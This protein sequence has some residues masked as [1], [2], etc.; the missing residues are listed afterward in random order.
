MS[1]DISTRDGLFAVMRQIAA[2]REAA[3]PRVADLLAREE[4]PWDEDIPEEWKTAGFVE[5]LTKAAAGIV[6]KDPSRCVQLQLLAVVTAGG[7]SPAYPSLVRARLLSAA[8]KETSYAYRLEGALDQ[9][10]QAAITAERIALAEPA[11]H[12]DVS[13]ARFMRATA[14]A[15]KRLFDAASALV[16]ECQRDYEEFGDLKRELRCEIMSAAISAWHGDFVRACEKYESLVESV[17]QTD[18]LHTLGVIYNNLAWCA[19]DAGDLNKASAAQ[20][21]ARKIYERLEMPIAVDRTEWCGAIIRLARGDTATAL[22]RLMSLRERYLERGLMHD[23]ALIGLDAVDALLALGD[24]SEAY[25]LTELV[26]EEFRYTNAAPDAL[27]AL[28]YL[29]DFLPRK[30]KARETVRHVRSFVE[31][32]VRYREAVFA[33]PSDDESY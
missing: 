30:Q 22:S 32:S 31:E 13:I 27:R 25:R 21:K 26:A 24:P 14:L 3:K 33:P 29:R 9:S 5:E 11:L 10:I 28:A 7:M 15:F 8:W 23:A 16:S 17:R 6:E 1:A 4:L 19:V 18:D 20:T 2:E 12:H